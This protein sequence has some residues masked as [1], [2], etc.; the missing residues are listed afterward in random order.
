MLP[1]TANDTFEKLRNIPLVRP[2]NAGSD[3]QGVQHA[4]LIDALRTAA[5]KRRWS[6]GP[7]RAHISRLGADLEASFTMTHGDVGP[8]I[9]A[10]GLA[11]SNAKRKQL[12]FYVGAS[13]LD[14]RAGIVTDAFP[15]GKRYTIGFVLQDEVEAALDRWEAF[16]DRRGDKYRRLQARK[17]SVEEALS[18][19][20]IAKN[21]QILPDSRRFDILDKFNQ[22]GSGNAWGLLLAHAEVMAGTT[23][24]GI[25]DHLHGFYSLLAAP[26]GEPVE[27]VA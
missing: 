22:G 7:L 14:G 4:Q 2:A 13:I 3:W 18:F 17:V 25:L 15:A 9:P 20:A 21:Q 23:P 24:A 19:L 5:R 8:T 10:I 1:P 11:V 6:P 27:L 26:V 12:R 16:N